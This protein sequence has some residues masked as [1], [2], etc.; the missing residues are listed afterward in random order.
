MAVLFAQ[1]FSSYDVGDTI[2]IEHQSVELSYCYPIDSLSST[3][4]LS[5]YAGNIIMIEMAASW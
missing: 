4:S 1:L 2:S 3:F 5:E